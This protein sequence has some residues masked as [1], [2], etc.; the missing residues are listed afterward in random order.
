MLLPLLFEG[1][2]LGSLL[3]QKL[4]LEGLRHTAV[5]TRLLLRLTTFAATF[6]GSS[7][8]W[9]LFAATLELLL[10]LHLVDVVDHLRSPGLSIER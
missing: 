6:F 10:H 9:L 5:E 3:F 1:G 4:L 7:C 2:L 8:S